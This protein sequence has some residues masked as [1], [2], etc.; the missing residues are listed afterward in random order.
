M[1]RLFG[2]RSIF[3][4]DQVIIPIH[5]EDIEHWSC[6]VVD[7]TKGCM[8]Y[9]D[10]LEHLRKERGQKVMKRVEEYLIEESA[11]RSPAY[12]NTNWRQVVLEDIPAQSNT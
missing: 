4:F 1:L 12:L 7:I 3:D 2:K 6:I 11:L 5:H 10:S 9:L 8:T